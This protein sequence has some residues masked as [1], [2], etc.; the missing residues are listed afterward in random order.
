MSKIIWITGAGSGIGA[1][2]AKQYDVN[3]NT[4]ILSGRKVEPLHNIAKT[5]SNAEVLP[6]DV[7]DEN[8]ILK[9]VSFVLDKY[10]K[11]DIL[12]NN[13]GVSQRSLTKDI[14]NEVGKAL[15][16][17]NFYGS[18][19]LTKAL[20][21]SMLDRNSGE[22]AVMSSA[23]GKFGFPL[24]SYYAAAKHALHGFYDTLALELRDT[25]IHILLVCPGRVNTDISKNALTASGK[26]HD[27]MDK[28]HETG[29][30]VDKCARMIRKALKR[31]KHEVYIGSGEVFLIYLKRYIPSLFWYIAKKV[32]P[33]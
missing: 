4:L 32:S 3:G 2:L 26:S 17:V 14:T 6:L 15:M 7:T 24:R 29:V 8:D 10:K 27:K 23:A 28:S 22:I 9:A 16:D 13:A 31:K 20:L 19:H 18:I 12:I 21:P 1:E 30:P 5:L 11:V 33:K 25:N